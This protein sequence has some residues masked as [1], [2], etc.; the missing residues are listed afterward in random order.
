VLLDSGRGAE[1]QTRRAKAKRATSNE[2]SKKKGQ[3]FV[4]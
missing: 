1:H 2:T 4:A 3:A